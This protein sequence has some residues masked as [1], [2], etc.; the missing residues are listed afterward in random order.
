MAEL[1]FDEPVTLEDG[2]VEIAFEVPEDLRYLEG[3]FPGD[4]MVPG[5]AQVVPLAERQARRAFPDLGRTVG[6]RRVKF[7]SALRPRQR[8]VLRLVRKS[9]EKVLFR[10]RRPDG[11]ECTKGT[12][13]F[14][15]PER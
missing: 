5:V 3:H 12:L 11:E 13:V 4:P 10:I 6:L 14:A 2:A 15:A 8:L 7:M 9:V 1:R